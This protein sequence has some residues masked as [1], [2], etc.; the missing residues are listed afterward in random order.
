ML[1]HTTKFILHCFQ[2]SLQANTL[3]QFPIDFEQR[4]WDTESCGTHA[5]SFTV[6][7]VMACCGLITLPPT[8]V[9]LLHFSLPAG[10]LYSHCRVD[11]Q[12]RDPGGRKQS[13]IQQQIYIHRKYSEIDP[14]SV[15]F[16]S[17]FKLQSFLF[18]LLWALQDTVT[19][20][21]IRIHI[22]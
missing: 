22:L 6:F 4:G 19:E 15:H 14:H 10:P 9:S 20:K 21:Q 3:L 12:D 5:L 16:L 8:H 2:T 1:H 11:P 17:F 7:R 13:S 18:F